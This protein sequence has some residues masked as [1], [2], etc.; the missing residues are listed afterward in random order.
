MLRQSKIPLGTGP[1]RGLSTLVLLWFQRTKIAQFLSFQKSCINL[2][3]LLCKAI[4]MNGHSA[5]F[6]QVVQQLGYCWIYKIDFSG[7][8]VKIIFISR[9]CRERERE[10]GRGG[11]SVVTP[12]AQLTNF[13][14]GGLGPREVHILYP[15]NHNFRICLPKK[16]TTFYSIPPK[17]P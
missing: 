16:I 14:N 7:T 5:V 15:K 17:I 10:M 9:H 11:V 6:G 2:A 12:G 3:F 8:R 4:K 13:I 1:T